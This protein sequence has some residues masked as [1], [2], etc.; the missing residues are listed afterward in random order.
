MYTELPDILFL[1]RPQD[2]FAG[3]LVT[4]GNKDI[5]YNATLKAMRKIAHGALKAYG[6]GLVEL[7]QSVLDEAE[8]LFKRFDTKNGKAFDPGN[9]LGKSF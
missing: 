1:G 2:S 3:Q 8:A 6:D 5:D 9:D 7:E 4:K